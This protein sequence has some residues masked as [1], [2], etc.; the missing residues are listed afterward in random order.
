MLCWIVT[1]MAS[2][3]DLVTIVEKIL[4]HVRSL[5]VLEH[6]K[7]GNKINSSTVHCYQHL[8]ITEAYAISWSIAAA[9]SYHWQRNVVEVLDMLPGVL[10]HLLF[11]V[12]SC[13][14]LRF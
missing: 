4:G 9:A 3:L 11:A 10:L 14:E 2:G 6:M 12:Y 13:Q 7:Y 8:F 5:K 1:E